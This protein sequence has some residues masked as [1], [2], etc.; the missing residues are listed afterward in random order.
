MSSWN[1]PEWKTKSPP[2]SPPRE[3][4]RKFD[5]LEYSPNSQATCVCC[6]EKIIKQSE[7]IGI[8]AKYLLPR[9]QEVWKLRYYHGACVEDDVKRKLYITQEHHKLSPQ[10]R[11]QLEK[12]L[13]LLR[14]SF[15]VA[16]G[17]EEEEYK[18]FP[19][20]SIDDLILKLPSNNAELMQCYGIKEKRVS[21]YGSAILQV[22]RPYLSQNINQASRVDDDE[23]DWI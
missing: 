23:S 6:G 10:Q 3:R 15:A 21:Y 7:R 19:N 9:R 8:Q 14:K 20:P 13:R 2:V 17:V 12:E 1:S 5:K 16:E 11:K 18:I 4:K 22:I